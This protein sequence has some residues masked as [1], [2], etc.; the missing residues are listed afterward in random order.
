MSRNRLL[1][2]AA[3][4]TVLAACLPRLMAAQV[5]QAEYA[6]RRATLTGRHGDG[7]YFIPGAPEPKENY[8]NFWQAQN[9]RYLTGFLEPGAA[10]LIVRRDGHD[11]ALLF[12]EPKDPAQEVWTGERLGVE[13]VRGATGMEGRDAGS[14]DTVL[15]SAL[16]GAAH[17][18]VVGDYSA[19]GADVPALSTPRTR[20]DQFLDRLKVRHAGVAVTNA[21]GTVMSLRARK[22]PAE[23]GLIRTAAKVSAAGHREVLR[24]IKPGMNEFEVQALAE[25][26]FRRNGGDR[27][28]YGSIVGSGPNST[29]LHYNRDDRF[30]QAGE[31]VNMDMATYYGGYSADI[32]RTVPVNGKY[33]PEQRD[34]YAIV[35]AA[36]KAAER[37][38]RPGGSYRAL[39]DAAL[40][41]LKTGLARLGL[42]ESP[43]ATYEE[44]GRHVPQYRLYYMHG[45][46]HPIGLDVHD[47]DAYSGGSFIEGSA[48]TIEPGIY[49]RANTVDI[50]PAT[51]ANQAFRG[52][53]AAAV[54]KYANI[55]IRVEDDYVVTS[56]GFDRISADVPREMDEIEREMAEPPGVSAR[57][58][59]T[60]E[61]Y[62]RIRP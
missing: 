39:D 40:D 31:V 23:V 61:A 22:S 1:A 7:V 16:A 49:V 21:T 42:I 58:A 3:A 25:Y 17:L 10:L 52:R 18:F 5:G 14:L 11:R 46:G 38:I 2:R 28:S 24:N 57:D 33:S 54:A 20:D 51:P 12:V 45:L 43:D 44:N 30:M 56:T 26:A 27:P 4:L 53:I 29:T 19:S 9:F 50:V 6:V 32:T 60:V 15:D 35:L 8:E 13:A 41:V 36:L 37:Q 48:F 59:A 62:R 55:G 34:V 47:V